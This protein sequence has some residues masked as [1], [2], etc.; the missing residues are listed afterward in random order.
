M[1]AFD[2]AK[3]L[4]SRTNAVEEAAIIRM[5]QKARDLRA[6]GLDVVSLTLGEPDFATPKFIQDAAAKAMAEGFTHYSPVAGLPELRAAIAGKLARENGLAYQPGEIVVA[7]GAKQ[8][9]TN[10][11]FALIDDGDEAM[12]LAPY[13]VAYDGIV[14]MAGGR[15]VVLRAG[16]EENFKVSAFPHRRSPL[17]AH[18][19]AHSQ[20]AQQPFRRGLV[21]GRAREARRRGALLRSPNG[22]RR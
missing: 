10:A 8:A 19:A 5:A 7:N 17:G 3:L 6:R 15:P 9:I 20:F 4:S 22:H 16:I 2:A 11:V 21:A 18:Q 13:W 1:T 14:R 12:F